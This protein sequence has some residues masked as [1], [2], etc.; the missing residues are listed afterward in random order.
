MSI[1]N[2]HLDL[3]DVRSESG[4]PHNWYVTG[5]VDRGDDDMDGDTIE[6]WFMDIQAALEFMENEL[7][8]GCLY[9]H[10]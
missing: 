8:A 9:L 1:T 5:T 10:S 6:N 2:N 7:S 3:I 4:N